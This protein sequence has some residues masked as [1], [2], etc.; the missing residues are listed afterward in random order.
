M[1]LKDVVIRILQ[2][3]E[4]ARGNDNYLYYK[5][6]QYMEWPLDL[7]YIADFT[8]TNQFETISRIRRKVQATNPLLL[9][10]KHITKNRKQRE[11]MF[12]D[13]AKGV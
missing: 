12:K 10:K 11:E 13:F 5:V 9:P 4:K 1:N 6:F 2:T 7:K 8:T 3:D